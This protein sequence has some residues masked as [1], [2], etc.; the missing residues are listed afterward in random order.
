M[1]TLYID[2]SDCV[3]LQELPHN[4]SQVGLKKKGRHEQDTLN[5]EFH[6]KSVPTSKNDTEYWNRPR[7]GVPDYPAFTKVDL[8]YYSLKKKGGLSKQQRKKRFALF[9]GRWEKTDLT[10]K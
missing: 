10:Y 4:N 3:C 5:E 2:L 6:V 9:G 1:K 7:C 8:S